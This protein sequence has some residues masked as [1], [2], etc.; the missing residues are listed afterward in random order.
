MNSTLL[1]NSKDIF[2]ICDTEHRVRLYA[3]IVFLIFTITWKVAISIT[4]LEI[5]KLEV[6]RY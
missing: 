5:K 1:N 6:Q 2:H 4:D 3:Y